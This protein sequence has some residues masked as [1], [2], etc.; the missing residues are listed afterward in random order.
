MKPLIVRSGAKVNLTLDVL[1]RRADGYH[2]LQSVVHAVDLWDTLHF[3]FESRAGFSL[4]C[5]RPELAGEENLC[6]KALRAWLTF[7]ENYGFVAISRLHIH[8]E[9]RIPTG[10]GLGGG[11][12]NAAATLLALNHHYRDFLSFEQLLKV[13]AKVGA[14]VPF[15][16]RGGCALMEGIGERLTPLPALDGWLVIIQPPQSLSTPAVYGAWD[17]TQR[18]SRRDTPRF[19]Q[20]LEQHDLSSAGLTLTDLQRAASHQTRIAHFDVAQIAAALGNDLAPAAEKLGLRVGEL[21]NLLRAHGALGAVM[22]GSGSAVFGLFENER[23]A[24]DAAH[25]I[26]ARHLKKDVALPL[27]FV[28]VARLCGD[29]VNWGESEGKATNA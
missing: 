19:L 22:T 28:G 9:K 2:E 6:W 12:G 4:T 3:D 11:S 15:F 1:A 26:E 8:L 13:G 23:A 20:T 7:A 14:D 21:V 27:S 10:A 29:S 17:E 25:R 5:N 18:P 24:R 16:L